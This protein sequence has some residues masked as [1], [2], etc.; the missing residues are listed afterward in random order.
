[1][2]VTADHTFATVTHFRAITASSKFNP[3][4]G[5]IGCR[6]ITRIVLT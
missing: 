6:E 2:N 5:V 4:E 1:M 3:S